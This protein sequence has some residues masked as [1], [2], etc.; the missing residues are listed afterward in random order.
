MEDN[1]AP[2]LSESD[3]YALLAQARRR[4]IV[5]CLRDRDSPQ[6]L[7]QLA[8]IIGEREQDSPSAEHLRRVYLSLYH[9]HLPKLTDS[10]IVRYDRSDGTVRRG[11]NFDRLVDILDA[12][13]ERTSSVDS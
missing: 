1:Q 6:T 11:P 2:E 4:Q 8:R 5:H 9:K 13:R 3:I 7:D 10:G 12:V